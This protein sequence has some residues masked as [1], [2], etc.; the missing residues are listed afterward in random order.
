MSVSEDDVNP[1][2]L[3]ISSLLSLFN[4]SVIRWQWCG[5]GVGHGGGGVGRCPLI[6]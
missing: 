4:R 5:G 2:S 3:S 1:E 6:T